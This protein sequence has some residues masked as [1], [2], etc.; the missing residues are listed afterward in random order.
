LGPLHPETHVIVKLSNEVDG[1]LVQVKDQGQGIP[2]DELENV[3][4][5]FKKTSVT[6][7]AG[8]S[9]NGLGLAIVKR[10][11]DAHGGTIWVESEKGVGSNF[12]FT[13][14]MKG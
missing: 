2:A 13:L 8:E 6:T 5:E 11:I 14:P 12:C 10:I 9:S 4:Q 1:L 3:F 7:T